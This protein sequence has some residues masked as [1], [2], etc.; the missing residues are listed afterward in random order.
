MIEQARNEYRDW[1]KTIPS[2]R[3]ATT[4]ARHAR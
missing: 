4:A 2:V 3:P 1:A